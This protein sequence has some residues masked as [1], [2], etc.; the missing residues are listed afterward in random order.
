MNGKVWCESEEGKGAMFMVE[1]PVIVHHIT[2]D[3]VFVS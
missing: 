1:L 3:I 2:Q